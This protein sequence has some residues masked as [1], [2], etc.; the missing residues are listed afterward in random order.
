[1]QINLIYGTMTHDQNNNTTHTAAKQDKPNIN[2]SSLLL[3]SFLVAMI[4]QKQ[5][6]RLITAV[7]NLI[8]GLLIEK[9][10]H[11]SKLKDNQ[12]EN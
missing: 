3:F 1:M 4:N 8:N 2:L 9:R 5:F 7:V 12:T 11:H 6:I 10:N